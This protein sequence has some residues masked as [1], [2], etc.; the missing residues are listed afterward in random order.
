MRILRRRVVCLGVLYV[1]SV[2]LLCP[3]SPSIIRE[4]TVSCSR[5]TTSHSTFMFAFEP[6]ELALGSASWLSVSGEKRGEESW[7][8][9]GCAWPRE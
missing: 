9:A 7:D 2:D 5:S 3:V 8:R 6:F 4:Q 1:A